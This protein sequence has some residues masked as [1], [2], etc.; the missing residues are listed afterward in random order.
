MDAAKTS[1]RA[2]FYQNSCKS[3]RNVLIDDIQDLAR[4]VRRVR[5]PSSLKTSGPEQEDYGR[6]IFIFCWRRAVPALQ[7]S[8]LR[9]SAGSSHPWPAF[10]PCVF[11]SWRG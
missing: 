7:R 3:L 11:Q 8:S 2:E 10:L 5:G 1:V 6:P 9:P 4:E